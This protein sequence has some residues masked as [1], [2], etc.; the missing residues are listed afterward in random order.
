MYILSDTEEILVLIVG[1]SLVIGLLIKS[2]RD[3]KSM[4]NEYNIKMKKKEND[5]KYVKNLIKE[6]NAKNEL[7]KK[8]AELIKK[9]KSN[10]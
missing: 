9:N 8:T 3:Y 1:L 2:Y 7:L 6:I 10:K 5:E 4:T